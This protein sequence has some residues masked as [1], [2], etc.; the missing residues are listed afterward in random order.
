MAEAKAKPK[1]TGQVVKAYLAALGDRDLDAAVALWKPGSINRLHGLAELEAPAEIKA[2]FSSLY[3]AFPDASLELLEVAASGKNGAGRWRLTGT[4]LGPGRFQGLLPTGSAVTVEGCDMFRVEDGLIVEN[5][6][7][8]NAAQ[9]AQQLGLLPP[10]GSAA[11][12]AVT[13]AF[14]AKTTAVTALRK[15]RDR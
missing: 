12:R 4:F 8:T 13:N 10:Q 15:L 2:Y 9:L 5:N 7:Y 1:S 11:D 14:N 3:S 6:A